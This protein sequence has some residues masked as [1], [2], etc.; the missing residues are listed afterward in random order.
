ME[1]NDRRKL[2]RKIAMETG[3]SDI[4]DLQNILATEHDLQVHVDVLLLDLQELN[5]FAGDD[6]VL[7][8]NMILANCNHQLKNLDTMSQMA[9]Y[10]N[11]RIKAVDSYFRNSVEMLKILKLVSGKNIDLGDS[12]GDTQIRFDRQDKDEDIS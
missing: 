7:L 6:K 1:K 9:K 12:S 4:K 11:Q 5:L 3:F 10:E 2:I 8:H